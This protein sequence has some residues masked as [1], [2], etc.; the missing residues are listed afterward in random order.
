MAGDLAQ[1]EKN[2]DKVHAVVHAADGKGGFDALITGTASIQSDFS[3]TAESD[4]TQAASACRSPSSS[5][6]SCSAPWWR[7]ACPSCSA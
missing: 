6:S 2:I 1:A 3:Q 7:R 5:C 4:L